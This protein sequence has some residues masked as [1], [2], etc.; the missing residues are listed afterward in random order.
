MSFAVFT[1]P[2]SYTGDLSQ[3][4]EFMKVYILYNPIKIEG[5][6][7]KIIDF[8]YAVSKEN[9]LPGSYNLLCLS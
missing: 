5:L 4:V 3:S 6:A 7:V 9:L 8:S 1:W 2:K